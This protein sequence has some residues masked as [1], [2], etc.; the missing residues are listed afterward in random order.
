MQSIRLLPVL[1]WALLLPACGEETGPVTSGPITTSVNSM[2]E[3]DVDAGELSK[4]ENISNET[5]NPWGRFV[6]HAES[7]CGGSPT[8]FGLLSMT[9]SLDASRSDV[10]RLEQVFTGPVTV[11]FSS[12]RGSDASAVRVDVGGAISVSGAGPVALEI[13]A[14]RAELAALHERLVGGDFHVGLR[15]STTRSEPF[16]ITP[17]VVFRA[18]AFCD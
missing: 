1:A 5:G 2:N 11:Y 3:S 15:G 9:L 4:D 8:G 6:D 7:E 10:D 12:T 17:V 16:S 18:Q 13:L 14:T